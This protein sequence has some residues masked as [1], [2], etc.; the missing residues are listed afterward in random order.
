MLQAELV[1]GGGGMKFGMFMMAL[2]GYRRHNRMVLEEDVQ[3]TVAC[4]RFGSS[5]ATRP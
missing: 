5:S 1:Q 3:S 4:V 2:N